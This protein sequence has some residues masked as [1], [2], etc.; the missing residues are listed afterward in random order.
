MERESFLLILAVLLA[1][2]AFA[3]GEFPEHTVTVVLGIFAAAVVNW[4]A[5]KSSSL[6]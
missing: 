4:L 2:T 6:R 1:T 3:M 5:R